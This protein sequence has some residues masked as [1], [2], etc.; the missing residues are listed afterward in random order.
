MRQE[1]ILLFG[2]IARKHRFVLPPELEECLAIQDKLALM[3][4]AKL[5]GEVLV[6]LGYLA[7]EHVR[8][9]LERQ[10]LDCPVEHED[11]LF[12]ELCAANGL[13]SMSAVERA[14]K[15]QA[16][17]ARK[18]DSRPVGEFLVAV[19]DLTARERDAI[20]ALQARVRR[21]PTVA[22]A[23]R[24]PQPFLM[25][26][27]DSPRRGGWRVKTVLV[28]TGLAIAAAAAAIAALALGLF[29]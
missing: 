14:L 17:A 27:T 16:K 10:E 25:F 15:A 1:Q 7:D 23:A 2:R 6:D 4:G 26:E 28:L 24:A 21:V 19:G 18:G 12:G 5:I 13:A 3:G 20:I 11:T 8:W 22:P 9:I 29:S